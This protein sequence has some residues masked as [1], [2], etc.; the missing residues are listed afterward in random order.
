[1][2]QKKAVLKSKDTHRRYADEFTEE[3]VQ[4]VLDGH[5]APS[6]VERLG[7]PYVNM[8]YR[9]KQGREDHFVTAQDF[10]TERIR[11]LNFRVVWLQ[12]LVFN[13]KYGRT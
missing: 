5:T 7:L 6:V 12:I 4:M 8:L 3:A 9:W 13:F 2:A 10:N 1:M 11:F